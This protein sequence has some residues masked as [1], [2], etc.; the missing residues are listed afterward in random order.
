M[1]S[2]QVLFFATSIDLIEIIKSIESS[3]DISFY[4]MGLFNEPSITCYKTVSEIPNFGVS[5]EGDWNKDRRFLVMPSTLPLN[6]REIPQ[7]KGGIKHAVDALENQISI[8]FQFGGNFQDN[9]IICGSCDSTFPSD[10]SE[11]I[12]SFFS[13]KIRKA[14]KKI[15]GFYVGNDAEQKL[16]LGWRLVTNVKLSKDFDL[17]IKNSD[18]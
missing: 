12:F 5:L 18:N 6:I 9:A 10:F 14:F 3:L 1:K 4:E 11:Q 7:R 15:E 16:Q 13:L 2:K 8:C 17:K